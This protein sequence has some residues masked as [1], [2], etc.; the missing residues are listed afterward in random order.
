MGTGLN[1][2]RKGRAARVA[3]GHGWC[4]LLRLH[5]QSLRVLLKLLLL[6]LMLVL[7]LNLGLLPSSSFGCPQLFQME[8]LPLLQQRLNM[9]YQQMLQVRHFFLNGRKLT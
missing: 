6:L 9:R 5:L 1:L 2:W 8:C 3:H 7:Q 4:H